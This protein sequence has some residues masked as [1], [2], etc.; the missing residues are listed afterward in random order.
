[1]KSVG[2][3]RGLLLVTACV[4]YVLLRWSFTSR[5]DGLIT[6]DVSVALLPLALG[7]GTILLR[8][9]GLLVLLPL[10]VYWGVCEAVRWMLSRKQDAQQGRG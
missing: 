9:L 7:A 4:V 3:K 10:G 2:S 8:L 5:S 1:M 6:S